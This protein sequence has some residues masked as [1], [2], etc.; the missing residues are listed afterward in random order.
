MILLPEIETNTIAVKITNKAEKK[1]RQRH[2]WI[3]DGSI[4][5]QN[6]EG[7]SGDLAILYS[8]K[9]KKLLAVGLWDQES[10][11]RIKLI[12]FLKPVRLTKE[13]FRN[14]VAKAFK[15]RE[16]LL[17]T[18]TNAYRLL[19]GENDQMPGFIAD[20]YNRVIVIK[21]YSACW[22]PY[23]KDI[24]E[25][26]QEIPNVQTGV[27]RLSRK[28]QSYSQKNYGL[29]DGTILFGILDNPT[30]IFKEHGIQFSAN[31]I[32]GHKTG[33]FLD[34]REN[35]RKVG[36]L[37]Q[38]KSVLDV[39]SYAGGFSVHALAGGA[40]SVISIDISK[41]ALLLAE[42][43]ASLNQHQGTHT[44]IAKDAFVALASLKKEQ[45]QFDIVVID[46]PAFAKKE[47]EVIK[48]IQMYRR[49]TKLGAALVKKNG[50]LVMASCSSRVTREVFYTEV[51]N[52]LIHSGYTFTILE[53]TAHDTDH[54]ITFPEGAYL[55]TGYYRI[56]S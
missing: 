19:F 5:K 14:T 29:I 3:F 54:P 27:L 51:E 4:T 28:L 53:K 52:T 33:Y 13:W 7:V 48:A 12:E 17:Q 45:R 47:S 39:F 24:L 38:N 35:R 55:K 49:L 46:P 37:S 42:Q 44:T 9:S 22:F 6:R 18:D 15:K 10:P 31:V 1:V 8:Q 2:P 36:I 23:L 50:I 20:V 43:N 21:L 26:L 56:D 40:A 30:I 41:Q 34:H 16:E 32:D 25:V 11:I